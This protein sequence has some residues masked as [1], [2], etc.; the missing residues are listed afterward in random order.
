MN[1]FGIDPFY[2]AGQEELRMEYLLALRKA[3]TNDIVLAPKELNS[4]NKFIVEF[5]YAA[6]LI[7]TRDDTLEQEYEEAELQV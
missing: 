4:Y 7:S 5:S 1:E 6:Y 3:K 2:A